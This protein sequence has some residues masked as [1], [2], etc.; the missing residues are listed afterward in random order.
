M[1]NK[2]LKKVLGIGFAAYLTAY[3]GLASYA[4]ID[5]KRN[6]DINSEKAPIRLEYK[7]LKC[8]I[9]GKKKKIGIIGEYHSYNRNET[10]YASSIVKQYDNVAFEGSDQKPESKL[11]LK[12]DDITGFIPN[13]FY[14]NGSHRRSPNAYL[15]ALIDGKKITHLEE[16]PAVDKLTF[17]QKS[18]FLADDIRAML[19]APYYYFKGKQEIAQAKINDSEKGASYWYTNG[20]RRDKEMSEKII[21]LIGD[22]KTENLLCIVGKS[23]LEG[24]ISNIEKK[25]KLGK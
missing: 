24:I 2:W 4:V 7:E 8:D 6:S 11:L 14:L 22:K 25:I 10:R 13:Y 20:E 15:I 16:K 5:S 3:A 19:I 12:A 21:Q 9:N 17:A 1:K 18:A 23:H